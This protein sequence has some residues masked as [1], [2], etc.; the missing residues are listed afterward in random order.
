MPAHRT[1]FHIGS[2][3][4]VGDRR[5]ING[6]YAPGR[7][8][9]IAE[10]IAYAQNG[11]SLPGSRM[12]VIAR[13][14]TGGGDA[15]AWPPVLAELDGRLVELVMKDGK[16]ITGRL[17]SIGSDNRPADNAQ[18]EVDGKPLGVEANRVKAAIALE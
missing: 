1:T 3:T 17:A 9:D 11:G 6:G 12:C 7:F 4:Y 2:F 16:S 8:S 15:I 18:I 5:N 13:P 10:A 14:A